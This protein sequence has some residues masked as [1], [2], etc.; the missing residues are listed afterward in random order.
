MMTRIYMDHSATSP[1]APEVLEAMLPYFS[2]KF[3]NASSLHSFGL[4]AKEALEEA[5]EK[6]ANLLG[7]DPE[8]IIFTSGGTE[9]DNLALKGI[10]RLH[11]QK[12]KHIITSSI[13]HPAILEVCR[14]LEKEGFE[15]TYLPVGSEGLVDPAALEAAIRPDTTLISIMHANNEIGTIQPVEEIGKIAA[16]KDIF[17]HTDAVQTAG[18]IPVD[19]DRLGVDLLS[20]SGHKFYGP[21]GVGALFIRKGTKIESIVQGGGHERSLRSGTENIPGIVGLGRAAEL[22]GQEMPQEMERLTGLRD[23]L[24]GYVLDQVPES[25]INGSMTHRLPFNLNFGFKYVEGESMLLYLDAKGVAVSTG[26]ACSS[27]KLEASHVLRALGLAPQDCHGSLRITMG[28]SNTSE[29]ADYAGRCIVEA[30]Q[31]FRG[32]SALGR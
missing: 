26:S 12:G 20:L 17:L 2:Q 21:K 5:R 24:A 27:H 23:R 14:I 1:V 29:D 22:A 13:E 15:V 28:R 8:E 18:K 30:V 19:V 3:G 11:R 32:I 4:E 16:E 7:A 25:W 6:V 10:A 9:S 31:R